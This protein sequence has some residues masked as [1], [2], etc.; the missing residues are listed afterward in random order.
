MQQSADTPDVPQMFCRLREFTH[1]FTQTWKI[2]M[3][4]V[5]FRRPFPLKRQT[6]T[7]R[8]SSPGS[9]SLSWNSALDVTAC[10]VGA[11]MRSTTGPQQHST[12]PSFPRMFKCS[13]KIQDASRALRCHQKNKK[14]SKNQ[15]SILLLEALRRSFSLRSSRN[16]KISYA[17]YDLIHFSN[18]T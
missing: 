2:K 6:A 10:A 16:G 3:A 12:Q 17:N 1:N 15:N 9:S 8:T 5:H 13:F 11:W 18:Q 4:L 14:T 7:E